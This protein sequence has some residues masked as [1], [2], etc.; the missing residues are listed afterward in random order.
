MSVI[1]FPRKAAN[2]EEPGPERI[3]WTC[4][5]G[6]ATF[7]IHPDDNA[8]CAGCGKFI[9]D[10]EATA[11]KNIDPV[12]VPEEPERPETVRV[13]IDWDSPEINL[14]KTQSNIAHGTT[15]VVVVIQQ[16]GDFHTWVGANIDKD[17]LTER[18]NRAAMMMRGDPLPPLEM[19]DISNDPTQ[20]ELDFEGPD[21]NH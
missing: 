15:A 10:P 19:R 3:I 5:C 20:V 2:S 8:E 4:N 12:P 13:M 1:N 16:D 6:C 7:Y 18:M 21:A 14:K 11:W 9:S 17:W